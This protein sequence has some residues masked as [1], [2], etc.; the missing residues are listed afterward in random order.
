MS[1]EAVWQN[2][3]EDETSSSRVQTLVGACFQPSRVTGDGEG[4]KL[5]EG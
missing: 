1:E 4:D 2:Y 3:N 5:T